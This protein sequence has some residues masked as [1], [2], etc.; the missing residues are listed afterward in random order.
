MWSRSFRCPSGIFRGQAL[1][2]LVSAALVEVCLLTRD[3]KPLL[4]P[5][6]VT[7]AP[8]DRPKSR[9]VAVR[10]GTTSWSRA[11]RHTGRTD[12][13][14]EN[15]G[16]REALA[17]APVLAGN[18]FVR[19][20]TSPLARASET[21]L[22]AGFSASAEEC[23]DLVE[24]DYGA[25]EG[26]TTAEIRAQRP[27]WSLWRDGVVDGETLEDVAERADSIIRL[28]RAIPGDTLVFS[29]G[30][31]LRV[32]CARWVE[33]AASEGARFA[34]GPGSIGVLGWEHELAVVTRWNETPEAAL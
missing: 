34:L 8:S 21:C 16:R 27:G 4:Y 11:G 19:V 5:A 22:L 28:V 7:S 26:L 15:E 1:D 2:P 13:P 32:V 25:Y 9:L 10:H 6:V 20:L 14:L 18:E 30:H 17:L 12:V 29:H 33:L 31:L 23:E 24:W 3:S